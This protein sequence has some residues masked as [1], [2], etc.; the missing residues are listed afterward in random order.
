MEEIR[1]AAGDDIEGMTPTVAVPAMLNFQVRGQWVTR[2]IMLIGIDESTHAQVSDFG[3]YL[4]HP[5]NRGSSRSGSATVATT[6]STARG[7]ARQV[8][9]GR[10]SRGPAGPTGGCGS[11]GNGLWRQRQAELQ[12]S[13]QAGG[14]RRPVRPVDHQVDA[15]LA[16]PRPRSPRP[17]PLPASSRRPPRPPPNGPIPSGPPSPRR[18]AR[19]G[20][21]PGSSSPASFPA[22]AWRASAIP[23]AST[24]SSC[25]PATT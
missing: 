4:Q 7:T 16:E 8:A 19:D 11:N 18:G 15:V 2:Q 14:L 1:R 12:A 13:V 20:S 10:R 22:S 17:R 3:R 21:R 24:A 9:R 23:P 6:R 25:S 5:D